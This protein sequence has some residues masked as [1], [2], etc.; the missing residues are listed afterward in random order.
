MAL[1]RTSL[2]AI[3][4]MWILAIIGAAILAGG[5]LLQTTLLKTVGITVIVVA[6]AVGAIMSIKET[7]DE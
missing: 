7:A 3:C 2:V 1:D 6:I 5:I 4:T